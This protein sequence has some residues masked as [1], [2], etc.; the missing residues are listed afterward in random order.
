MCGIFGFIGKEQKVNNHKLMILGL[1]NV[2]RGFDA[3]GVLFRKSP[4]TFYM[5]KEPISF[6]KFAHDHPDYLDKPTNQF[7]GHTRAKTVGPNTTE[8]AH[9]FYNE[10]WNFCGVHNGTLKNHEYMYEVFSKE[11]KDIPD[12]KELGKTPSDSMMAYN[13]INGVGYEKLL[14]SYEGAAALV[15]MDRKDNIYLYHDKERALHMGCSSEGYYFSS[16][17]EPLTV[18]GCKDIFSLDEEFLYKYKDGQLIEK[19]KV[20]RKPLKK[21]KTSNKTSKNNSTKKQSTST[22]G[23][24]GCTIRIAS[25]T[26]KKEVEKFNDKDPHIEIKLHDKVISLPYRFYIPHIREIRKLNDGS[27]EIITKTDKIAGTST[28]CNVVTTDPE[29]KVDMAF[30]GKD[31]GDQKYSLTIGFASLKDGKQYE[32]PNWLFFEIPMEF[33]KSYKEKY[34]KDLEGIVEL[35]NPNIQI[36]DMLLPEF[37]ELMKQYSYTP[38]SKSN[39]PAPFCHPY[40]N[41]EVLGKNV[42]DFNRVLDKE[43]FY[44]EK[45]K[46]A[47]FSGVMKGK[48]FILK[49]ENKFISCKVLYVNESGNI[50]VKPNNPDYDGFRIKCKHTDL[51]TIA[52]Y[53]NEIRDKFDDFSTEIDSIFENEEMIINFERKE[54][55]ESIFAGIPTIDFFND[56]HNELWFIKENNRTNL[57]NESKESIDRAISMISNQETKHKTAITEV[58]FKIEESK[59][60]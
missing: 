15:F 8:N 48:D 60:V 29:T 18:I 47:N 1:Y 37:L 40:S 22:T 24:G 23:K 6:F 55:L 51:F 59:V 56:L 32:V 13:I 3:S 4:S 30:V 25:D 16:E 34:N 57:S 7:I 39:L 10:K 58:L 12:I 46:I 33:V 50:V 11:C 26:E 19:K 49:L 42:I 41:S 38:K 17:A 53:Y 20:D 5:C 35:V 31:A 14:Q 2:K 52:D 36:D 44:E 54:M 45:S 27:H 9:P 28:T 21:K 43:T